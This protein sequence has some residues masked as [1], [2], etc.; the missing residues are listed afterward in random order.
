MNYVA[1]NG[2]NLDG[3]VVLYPEEFPSCARMYFVVETPSISPAL[4]RAEE[5]FK[6]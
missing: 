3:R 4:A 6:S 1:E 2:K 5:L